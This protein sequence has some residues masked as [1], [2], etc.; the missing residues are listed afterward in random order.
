MDVVSLYQAGVHNVA[1]S[2]GTALTEN[3]A[4]LIKRY[5]KNVVLS[6][7]ADNAGQNAAFRGLDILYKTGCRARVL[8][9]TDGKDPDEFIKRN[10]KN[11]FIEL[12]EHAT[13]YGDFKLNM[14]KQRYDTDDEQ[15]RVEFIHDAVKILQE[16]NPVEADIYIKKLSDEMGISERA[17]RFEYRESANPDAIGVTYDKR[18]HVNNPSGADNE[19]GSDMSPA[20]QDLIKLMLRSDKYMDLP[21]DVAQQAFGSEAGRSLYN[22]LGKVERKNGHIDHNRLRDFLDED[23]EVWLEKIQDE[24]STISDDNADTIF[25]DCIHSIRTQNLKKEEDEILVRLSMADEVEN[26]EEIVA[27]TQRLMQIQKERKN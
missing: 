1:A 21:E 18:S 25:N 23:V 12:A 7:D 14:V 22:A 8:K 4:R 17:I 13:A 9:V 5:T 3:Q 26:K 10:G 27:L 15:Q 6:Y 24:M 19:S 16:M 20:E 11:A 2:L